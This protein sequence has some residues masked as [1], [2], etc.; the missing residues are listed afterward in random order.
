MTT[1]RATVYRL[2]ADDG[3]EGWHE[4]GLYASEEDAK[5]DLAA[6]EAAYPGRPY[7][8]DFRVEALTVIAVRQTG[9][10]LAVALVALADLSEIEA[11][12]GDPKAPESWQSEHGAPRP[13]R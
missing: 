10:E 4:L 13:P 2:T 8:I 6:I 12:W 11:R 5:A 9:E 3:D 7:W 1:E